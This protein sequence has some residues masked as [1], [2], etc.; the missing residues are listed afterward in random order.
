[1][2]FNTISVVRDGDQVRSAEKQTPITPLV[3]TLFLCHLQTERC[4]AVPDVA[5]NPADIGSGARLSA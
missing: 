4:A 3:I 1:M 5:A 2:N